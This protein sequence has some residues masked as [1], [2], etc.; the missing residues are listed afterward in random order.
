M[1]NGT[2]TRVDIRLAKKQIEYFEYA[3]SLGGFKTLTDFVI[4][5]GEQQAN[6]IVEKHKTILASK[7]DQE[8]FFDALTNPQ[9]AN[10]RLKKAASR[11]KKLISK[12]QR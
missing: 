5:S 8:I 10:E 11:Y 9:P 1:S 7:R 2:K 6:Q 12:K 3:A 4:F